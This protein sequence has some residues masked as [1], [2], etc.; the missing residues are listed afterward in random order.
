MDKVTSREE[1]GPFEWT[2]RCPDHVICVE[3]RIRVWGLSLR[4]TGLTKVLGLGTGA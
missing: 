1:R 4:V 2:N 3:F